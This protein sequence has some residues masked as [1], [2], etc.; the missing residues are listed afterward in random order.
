MCRV[1]SSLKQNVKV[2][3]SWFFKAFLN[4]QNMHTKTSGGSLF[5]AV[6][7]KIIFQSRTPQGSICPIT[8]SSTA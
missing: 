4:K 5:M 2:G 7:S 3:A 1:A 8:E 6:G